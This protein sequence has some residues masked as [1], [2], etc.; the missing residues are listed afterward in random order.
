MSSPEGLS[1]SVSDPFA[2]YV[3]PSVTEDHHTS[4]CVEQNY[5]HTNNNN[6]CSPNQRNHYLQSNRGYHPQL[7]LRNSYQ[8]EG[9]I[10]LNI[11]SDLMLTILDI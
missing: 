8:S 1:S 10:S 2:D 9:K 7:D 4:C 11:Y 3:F 5:N 6:K